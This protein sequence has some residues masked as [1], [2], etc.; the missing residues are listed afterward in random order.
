MAGKF[1]HRILI[2]FIRFLHFRFVFLEYKCNRHSLQEKRNIINRES[3][4][5]FSTNFIYVPLATHL[6]YDI[7][8]RKFYNIITN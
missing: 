3:L 6:K 8:R 5:K 4:I 7:S 1:L 2:Y